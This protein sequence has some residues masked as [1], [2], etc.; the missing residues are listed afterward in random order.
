MDEKTSDK[1][2]CTTTLYMPCI[3]CLCRFLRKK[4]DSEGTGLR[5][6]NP[7]QSVLTLNI[8]RNCLGPFEFMEGR[9]AGYGQA[10]AWLG[11]LVFDELE[12]GMWQLFRLTHYV[13][14]T[15]DLACETFDRPSDLIYL[16]TITAWS[17][18]TFFD[19]SK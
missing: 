5:R 6:T 2:Y 10:F 7:C 13:S 15:C 3:Y 17:S 18:K 1:Q 19:Y 14:V 11:T 8:V 4:E 16:A 9:W 12:C